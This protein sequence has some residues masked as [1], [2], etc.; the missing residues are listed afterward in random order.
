MANVV[1]II[2]NARDQA[3]STLKAI[4]G[5]MGGMARS[6]ERNAGLMQAMAG[7]GALA[8]GAVVTSGAKYNAMLES[9]EARWKT[10]T[11]SVEGANKQMDYISQYA[12][13]SPFDYQGIDETATS[14]MGMGMELETVN[15]WIPTLGDMA[16]VLGGG[17]ETIK[18]VG[19]ALGQMN[20]KGKVSAEEMGQLAE[21]GVNAW[22]MIADGM[23]LSVAEVRK[24]SEEGKLLSKDALPLIQKGMSETFG[25]G[26]AE[27]MKSTV[28]QAQ[29][30]QESF[31][32]LAGTLTSG[33]YNWFGATILPMIN[34]GLE[35]LTGIFS[36]G[37]KEGFSK[38]FTGEHAT[39]ITMI[40]G[41]IGGVL[42][43]ALTA[44]AISFAPAIGMATAFIAVGAGIGLLVSKIVANWSTFAPFFSNL[45]NVVKSYVMG[46]VTQ[47][48]ASFAS[49]VAGLAPLWASIK[50]L[51]NSLKPI[52][53]AVG[54]VFGVLLTVSLA[55][56]N[57]IVS[58]IAPLLTAFMNLADVVVN[59]VMTIVHLLTGNWSGAMQTWNNATQSAVD[60][61]KNIWSAIVGFFSGF[62]GTFLSILS[63]FGVNVVSGFKSMWESAKSA[64]SN[65]VK[66]VVNFFKNLGSSIASTVSSIA[67][68]VSSGFKNMM[69]QAGS[70][71]SSGISKVISFFTKLGSQ[72]ASTVSSIASKLVSGFRNMMSQ[73]ASAVSSGVGKI[74]SAIKG[75]GS[76]FVSAGKGLLDAFTKGIKSGISKAVG[77]VKDGMSKIR[78]FL[79]FSPAKKG[80]L[81]DLDK[82]GESFFPTW[83][84]GALKKVP[85]MTRAIGGAMAEVSGALTSEFE[86]VSLA[87]FSGGNSRQTVTIRVE[88]EVDVKGD[89][90]KE[91]VKMVSQELSTQISS[92]DVISGLRQAIRKR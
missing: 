13:S 28:G 38:L 61:F 78:S 4:E 42:V 18:G 68:K 14:L 53:S 22:Q 49:L 89:S 34:S 79:P 25:G 77:A 35:K 10:L 57:G 82:S 70:A 90:G 80:A 64:V 21:R 60:F 8:L 73:G 63:S 52:L 9:S 1:D 7:A 47:F 29:Q 59:V 40:A 74:V 19:V 86:P 17:T 36:G 71:V 30:A 12:K 20:A 33:A 67:S 24:L 27:Y 92:N 2:V 41:A 32:Q 87:D 81:S 69:S 76:T 43:G 88:G 72:I 55:T 65:G 48:Q 45:F 6:I 84:N 23:G 39:T 51:F 56:F 62:V 26:T 66:A 91:Q 75:F 3:S 54:V 11:G 15:N 31:A 5:S 85:A 50:T 37:L 16:S 46:F 83:Y 58:A 44:L